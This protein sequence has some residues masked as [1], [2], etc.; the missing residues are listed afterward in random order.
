MSF[1]IEVVNYDPTNDCKSI[2]S[3]DMIREAVT[4]CKVMG[5]LIN[6]FRNAQ[7][8]KE[9]VDMMRAIKT[10]HINGLVL[11]IEHIEEGMEK[12]L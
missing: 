4:E 5:D 2:Y 6:N 3:E 7:S 9:K 1:Y 12:L 10:K 11:V 8:T